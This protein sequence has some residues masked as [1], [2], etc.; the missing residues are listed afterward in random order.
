MLR[1]RPNP[2]KDLENEKNMSYVMEFYATSHKNDG[3][4]LESFK[5]PQTYLNQVQ[6]TFDYNWNKTKK[7]V[8]SYSP[9]PESVEELDSMRL[10]DPTIT[11]KN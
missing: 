11:P 5:N 7:G 1:T 8:C 6:N 3:R 9:L 10:A 4:H 2:K